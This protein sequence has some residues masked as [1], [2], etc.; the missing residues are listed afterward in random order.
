MNRGRPLQPRPFYPIGQIKAMIRSGN[1][2][3]KQPALETAYNDFLWTQAEIEKCLLAL[4]DRFYEDDRQRNHFFKTEDHLRFA[5][6][7]MDYYKVRDF[8]GES[9]YLHFYIHP[10][11]I[12]VT[13]SSFKRL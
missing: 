4:N 2:E 5:N 7:K 1:I 8:F 11:T 12:K 6:T 13:V 9:V 3:V 10:D